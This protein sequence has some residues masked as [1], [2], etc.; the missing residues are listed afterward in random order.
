MTDPVDMGRLTQ[1]TTQD[2]NLRGPEGDLVTY[3]RERVRARIDI[4]EVMV[5]REF[6]HLKIEVKNAAF[7]TVAPLLQADVAVLAELLASEPG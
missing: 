5:T 1:P 6:H 7:R 4:Q 2:L 3:S